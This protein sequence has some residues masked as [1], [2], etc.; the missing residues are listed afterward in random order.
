MSNAAKRSSEIR[1]EKCPLDLVTHWSLGSLARNLAF[2]QKDRKTR[3][4]PDKVRKERGGEEVETVSVGLT[5]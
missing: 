1:R 4:G 2:S 3:T 5:I